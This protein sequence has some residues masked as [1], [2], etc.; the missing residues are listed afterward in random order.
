M[1]T[2]R[3]IVDSN[4]RLATDNFE[5]RGSRSGNPSARTTITP[6][7][8][9]TSRRRTERYGFALNA[10]ANRKIAANNTSEFRSGNSYILKIL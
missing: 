9:S 4:R 10:F 6:E 2:A 3:W 7:T 5:L 8:P 1:C